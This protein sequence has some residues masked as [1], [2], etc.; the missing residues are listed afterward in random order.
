MMKKILLVTGNDGHFAQKKF[1]WQSLD[2]VNMKERLVELGYDVEIM[3]FQVLQK[4][5]FNEFGN[6][7]VYTSSQK[8]ELKKYIE[9][10]M[11]FFDR[12]NTLIPSY[13]ALKAHDNKGFQVYMA[14]KYGFNLIESNYF[15]D[16]RDVTDIR[17]YPI[18]FK[19]ANGASSQGVRL[20][21]VFE[22]LKKSVFFI[23]SISQNI[24]R[25][26]RK[27]K[28]FVFKARFDKQWHEYISYGESRFVLQSFVKGLD[29]DYKVLV[30][31]EK[32]YI[33]KR[34]IQ[35]NDFR[36]SGS[37][38]HSLEIGGDIFAVLDE[39]KAFT[40]KYPSHVYS[41]D[42]CVSNQEAKVIEFQFT[43]VGPVTLTDSNCYYISKNDK[44]KKIEGKSNLEQEY[45]NA[46]D[47]YINRVSK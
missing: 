32:Y 47:I 1:P 3:T 5:K 31:G 24:V 38:L 40:E 36:A 29:C 46:I 45:C 9:D 15:S 39:A 6:Y 13:E 43:H 44:W 37:G 16:Y 26:K 27:L 33:L 19:F 8:I 21:K 23:D 20:I 34:F 42:I 2:V 18:V 22:D 41:L 28:E 17:D 10:T 12:D 7:I 11:Y 14:K 4:T 30:F 25:L 35:D